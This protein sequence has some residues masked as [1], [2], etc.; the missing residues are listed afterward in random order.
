MISSR[1]LAALFLSSMLLGACSK[2]GSS[3]DTARAPAPEP[4]PSRTETTVVAEPS[5]PPAMPMEAPPPVEAAPAP[6]PLSDAQITSILAAVDTGE[7]EQAKVAQ[8]KSKNAG[9]KKFAQHM[10]QQHTKSKQKGTQ[11]AKKAKIT[12]EESP[13][14]TELTSKATAQLESLKN[15]DAASIDALY[16][17]GQAAQHQEVLDLINAQLIPSA[18]DNDL[19]SFLAEARTM[20]E[21][22]VAQAN[23]LQGTLSASGIDAGAGAGSSMP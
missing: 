22:H 17:S 21:A 20:V 4:M 11:L 2:H 5:P 19:K 16:I 1:P 8:K 13:V 7:I 15:A 23:E 18:T 12:P 9:V 6:A 14:A 10:I 3:P